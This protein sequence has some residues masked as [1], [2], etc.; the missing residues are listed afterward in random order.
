MG[1]SKKWL[2]K[3][4]SNLLFGVFI[5]LII[6]PTTRMPI[7][8]FINRLFLFSPSINKQETLVSDSNFKWALIDESGRKIT[9]EQFTC[10]PILLNFWASWCPPC[11]AEMKSIE[12]AY[13]QTKEN[14][15]FVL[16]SNEPIEKLIAF[17]QK[18][19]YTFPVYQLISTLPTIFESESIPTTFLINKN[20]QIL[21]QQK[22]AQN[23]ASKEVIEMLKQ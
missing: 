21:I 13:L 18:K 3:N 12:S 16:V 8:V 9:A 10:K 22:G 17:K 14:A 2:L 5:V 7:Q 19:G 6:I 1:F 15:N 20:N 11:V 4:W 23:W